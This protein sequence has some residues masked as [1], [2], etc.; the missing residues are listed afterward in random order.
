MLRLLPTGRKRCEGGQVLA[1]TLVSCR[2][3]HK[4]TGD[5]HNRLCDRCWR[6]ASAVCTGPEVARRALEDLEQH[7]KG[8][9]LKKPWLE[10]RK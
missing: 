10:K 3:C 1:Q 6:I 9:R 8:W 2:Y 4:P 5:W 7:G